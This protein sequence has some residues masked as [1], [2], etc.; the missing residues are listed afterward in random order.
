MQKVK[1]VLLET[2][3]HYQNN[4]VYTSLWIKCFNYNHITFII[5]L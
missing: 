3:Y 1:T 5:D 4:G 2:R